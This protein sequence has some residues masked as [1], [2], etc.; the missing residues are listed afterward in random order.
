MTT[1]HARP[2]RAGQTLAVALFAA[3]LAG[4]V[5]E[6]QAS[7]ALAAVPSPAG[8]VRQIAERYRVFLGGLGIARLAVDAEIGPERY[9][10]E[11]QIDARGLVRTFFRWQL[12]AAVEGQAARAG[13]RDVLRPAEFRSRSESTRRSQDLR[14]AYASGA[15]VEIAA[16]PPYP[17]QPWSIEPAAQSDLPD[18][19]TAAIAYLAPRRDGD[20]CRGEAEI[21]DGR[22][23]F[24]IGFSGRRVEDTR[25]FCTATYR[26]V[27]GFKPKFMAKP[28]L[29]FEA[30]FAPGSGGWVLDKLA[31]ETPYGTGTMI[32]Q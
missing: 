17:D 23:R 30:E 7:E 26:R 8:D 32:R 19:L 2:S 28:D 22:R 31:I 5:S 24:A 27:A 6:A 1:R 21:Y 10:A 20:V 12:A 4:P 11:A 18:P 13:F 29:V 15:P 14:I 3:A 9:R 25:I 16:E